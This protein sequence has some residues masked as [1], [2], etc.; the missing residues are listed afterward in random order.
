MKKHK[1]ILG[2]NKIEIYSLILLTYI[3]F[4]CNYDVM[5]QI[6]APPVPCT[7]GSQNTCQCESSPLLCSMDVLNGYNFQMTNFLHPQDGPGNGGAPMCAGAGNSTASHNPTWFR[8]VAWCE[9]ID[10]AVA[11][12]NCNHGGITNCDA[13]GI[14]L[15]VFP[16]CNWQ[17]PNNSV[18]CEVYDCIHQ[19][20]GPPWDHTINLNMTGLTIG[21]TYSMVVDGCCN[22]ACNITISVTSPPCPPEIGQWQGMIIGDGTVNLGSTHDYEVEVPSGGLEFTWYIDG[23][24]QGDAT[25]FNGT[26]PTTIKTLTWNTVGT[27]QLCV[28][29]RNA[30]VLLSSDPPPLCKTI[31][32]MIDTDGDNISNQLDNCPTIPNPLQ[33][34]SD[35]DG[36]GDACD[37]CINFQ[38]ANQLDPD[39]DGLG[40]LCDNC[41]NHSNPLQEDTDN[42]GIG[43]ICDNCP[44]ISNPDQADC[45]NN[46]IGDLCDDPD[47]DC[48][49]IYDGVDNCLAVYNPFQ[50][51]QNQ[52]GIGDACEVFPKMGINT[53]DPKTELHLS[54]GSLYIDNPEK[55]IILKDYHGN[56]HIVKIINGLINVS[57]I[58]CP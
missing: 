55:G 25:Q 33:G 13:R 16:E 47:Q 43:N 42:D 48:D 28:D 18:T 35:G 24:Q 45:N 51:D 10:L 14:Q 54:N 44:T 2:Q 41:P 32:V 9:D 15:A 36:V 38:N 21:E 29:T 19:S 57:P 22:S 58:T 23:V 12:T 40:S 6:N 46:G 56:C 31:T 39:N 4:S 27:Y 17:D 1:S 20:Q 11:A 26:D 52:N 30:C 49:G 37:N 53:N 34:D 8:F 50:I 7:S 3:I 5:G